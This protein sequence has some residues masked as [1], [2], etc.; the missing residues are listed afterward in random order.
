MEVGR[1]AIMFIR[2]TFT[3]TGFTALAA[4]TLT[5]F[6][7]P[8]AAACERHAPPCWER[9]WIPERCETRYRTERAPE[10]RTRTVLVGYRTETRSVMR[11]REVYDPATDRYVTRGDAAAETVRVP[12]YRE[13]RYCVWVERQVAYTVVIPGRWEW[14]YRG[15]RCPRPVPIPIPLPPPYTDPCPPP[16][17]ILPDPGP[18]D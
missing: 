8:P 18:C 17:H 6:S 14:G 13:E 7:A 1:K 3:A 4:L 11:P 9:V 15:C 5:L 12:V 2:H 16:Y 10:W